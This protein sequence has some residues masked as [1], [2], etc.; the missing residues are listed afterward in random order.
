V[1]KKIGNEFCV[2]DRAG[3]KKLGCHPTEE[4][5]KEQLAAIEAAKYTS[6]AQRVDG[7]EIFASGK[8]NGDEYSDADL[9]AMV[10]A[11]G[12]LDYKPP[13]KA[14][15][16]KDRPGM[17]ALGWV[18]NLRRVGSKLVADF[19]DIPDQV[20]AVLRDKFYDT[21]SAEIYWDLERAGVTHPRALKAVALLGA[22]IPAVAGLRPLHDMFADVTAAVHAD[23][24]GVVTGGIHNHIAVIH[25]VTGHAVLTKMAEVPVA[26]VLRVF[27]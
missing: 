7:V 8:H 2:F 15:H 13:L 9:D 26:Y 10:E 18:D 16:S 25:V 12:K 1:I 19:V 27:R 4:K 21:V 14:G 20:Y 11:Y 24:H 6:Y 3:V 17:P 5:A 23:V 22:E